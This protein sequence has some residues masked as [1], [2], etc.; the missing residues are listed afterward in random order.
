MVNK[1]HLKKASLL[2][3]F[4]LLF[5]DTSFVICN[6]QLVQRIENAQEFLEDF[7]SS[8]DYDI[9]LSLFKKCRGIIILRQYKAGFI[10]GAKGG[11]GIALVK[12][13]S[14]Q[15]WRGP[16]F[17]NTGEGSF[18]FQVGGQALDSIFLIMNQQGLD[19]LLK[20]KFKIGVDASVAVG[21]LGRDAEAKVGPDVAL[22]AYSKAKGLYAGASFE[23]GLL[24][25]DHKSNQDFYN[26]D[27]IAVEDILLDQN[28][29]I[30]KDVSSLIS[31]LNQYSQF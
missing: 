24:L 11:R 18:G 23:G 13:E 19:M 8:P 7:Q 26:Q 4:V 20:L 25:I 27:G 29:P 12:D 21:P 6:D 5:L 16:V 15:T 1:L 22:L 2:L 17:I 28:R 31:L 3:S 9:P 10:F 14:N 30:L